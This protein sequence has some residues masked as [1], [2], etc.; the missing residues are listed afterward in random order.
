MIKKQLSNSCSGTIIFDRDK[1]SILAESIHYREDSVVTVAGWQMRNKIHADT[2]E[3]R[4][5]NR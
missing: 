5:R 1:N 2:F 3:T 4:F